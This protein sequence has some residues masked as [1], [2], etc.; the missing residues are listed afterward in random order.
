[1]ELKRNVILLLWPASEIGRRELLG[2][3]EAERQSQRQ[4]Q[5]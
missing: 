4:R 5:R 2:Q 3:A 1:M